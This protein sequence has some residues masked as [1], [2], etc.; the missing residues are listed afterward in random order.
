MYSWLGDWSENS[1]KWTAELRKQVGGG[2]TVND[3]GLFWMSFAKH[4][5]ICSRI[6]YRATFIMTAATKC[7]HTI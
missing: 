3:H 4:V 7:M 6:A 1:S 5:W 2:K